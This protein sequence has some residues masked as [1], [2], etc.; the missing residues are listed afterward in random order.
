MGICILPCV[1]LDSQW[2]FTIWL[3]EPKSIALDH[4]EGWDGVRSGREIQG[5]GDMLYLWLL[6]VD[7]QKKP[8]QSYKTITLQLK[9]GL[10]KKGFPCGSAGKEPT[11][12]VGD[13]GS[14]PE[15][16]RS[17]GEGKGYPLQHSGLENS[18]GCIVPGITKSWTWLSNFHF[19]SLQIKKANN[20]QKKKKKRAYTKK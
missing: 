8:A 17:P 15:L 1:K 14:S 12:H 7:I 20:Y 19:L 4:L 13:L 18:M 11:C 10:N 5:G 2:K 16:G 3:R 9:V 6:H